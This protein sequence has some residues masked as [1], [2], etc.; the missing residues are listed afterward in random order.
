MKNFLLTSC[1]VFALAGSAYAADVSGSV[2]LEATQNASDDW[3]GKN[4]VA[5]SFGA[6]EPDVGAFGSVGLKMVDGGTVFL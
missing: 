6:N 5:L 2:K 3:V 4:T 1:A